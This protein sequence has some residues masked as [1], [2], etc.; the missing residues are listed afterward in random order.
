VTD[1]ETTSKRDAN[2]ARNRL[3]IADA[4]A[5]LLREKGF[6]HFTVDDV[7]TVAGVSRRTFFNHFPTLDDAIFDQITQLLDHVAAGFEERLD[8]RSVFDA[9]IEAIRAACDPSQLSRIAAIGQIALDG[10]RYNAYAFRWLSETAD[11]LAEKASRRLGPKVDAF[12]VR[13]F[14]HSMTT[15]FALALSAWFEERRTASRTEDLARWDEL[16]DTGTRFVRE[17]FQGPIFTAPDA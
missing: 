3:A 11:V 9:A 2:K 13:A 8:D 4:T 17:G 12:Y 7:A 15:T 10:G 6:G 14:M 1:A 5:D 16:L